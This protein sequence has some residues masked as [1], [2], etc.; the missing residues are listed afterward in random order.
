MSDER[1]HKLMRLKRLISAPH[2]LRVLLLAGAFS[3]GCWIATRPTRLAAQ[4]ASTQQF[5]AVPNPAR[6]ARGRYLVEGPAHCLVC[7]SDV[8]WSR[9]TDPKPGRAASGSQFVEPMPF[10]LIC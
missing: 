2:L 5:S 3:V 9:G 8:D 7:H 10:R 4:A 6:L 1:A